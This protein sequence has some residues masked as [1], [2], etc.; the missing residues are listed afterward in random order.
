MDPSELKSIV[1]AA[2]PDCRVNADGDGRHFDLVVV[3][4]Q[5]EG[6]RT[7]QRQQMVFAALNEHIASGS[8]HAVNMKVYTPDEW[9]ARQGGSA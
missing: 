8:V 4:E 7:I 6:K 2:L 5:F 1:E 9:Q 3:G